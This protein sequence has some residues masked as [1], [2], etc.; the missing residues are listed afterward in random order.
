M[1]SIQLTSLETESLVGMDSL[2][3]LSVAFNS[4]GGCF[5]CH[6]YVSLGTDRNIGIF[7]IYPWVSL[8]NVDTFVVWIK[9][10]NVWLMEQLSWF[11][12]KRCTI[13]ALCSTKVNPL[14]IVILI[15]SVKHLGHT[16]TQY[17]PHTGSCLIKRVYIQIIHLCSILNPLAS[18][19]LTDQNNFTEARVNHLSPLT[20]HTQRN[21]HSLP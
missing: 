5:V 13:Q 18:S 10:L 11:C 7:V 16:R 15:S 6:M 3:T 12:V 1:V 17:H 9:H 20:D 4:A 2:P 19:S 14:G 21:I 8:L